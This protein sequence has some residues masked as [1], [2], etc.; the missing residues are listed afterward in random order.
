M[1]RFF[2]AIS[3]NIK[4]T[5]TS[6]LFLQ[7]H[8]Q[9]NARAN[10]N[11]TTPDAQYTGDINGGFI[12]NNGQFE[13]LNY[14]DN[15]DTNTSG[16][17]FFGIECPF[18]KFYKDEFNKNTYIGKKA[19]GS[20]GI[21]EEIGNQDWNA[22]SNEYINDVIAQT[23][24]LKAQFDLLGD[25]NS[26]HIFYSHWGERDANLQNSNFYNDFIAIL[27]VINNIF[28]IDLCIVPVLN[29]NV[30]L[31]TVITLEG[32]TLIQNQQRQLATDISY[33]ENIEMSQFN[34]GADDIHYTAEVQTQLAQ[35]VYNIYKSKFNL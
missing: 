35:Q 14:P 18:S 26:K 8:G 7:I 33:I 34:L 19:I 25:S 2:S 10:I 20:T 15:N 5:E 6:D 32:Q 27:G 9:S 28:P 1:I 16:L 30:Y 23:N 3:S 29:D 24:N 31:N 22:D 17:D 11:N 12:Y 21:G 4:P 13:V